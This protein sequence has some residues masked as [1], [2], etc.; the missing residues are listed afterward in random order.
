M[1]VSSHVLAEVAQTV[2]EVVIIH[3]GKLVQQAAME[4]VLAMAAGTTVVR[5]PDADGSPGC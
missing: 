4:D 1:L 3:R 2:D 5:S